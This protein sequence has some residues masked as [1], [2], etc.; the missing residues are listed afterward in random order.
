MRISVRGC[1][2]VITFFCASL[3]PGGQGQASL[4]QVFGCFD[5]FFSTRNV[6]ENFEILVAQTTVPSSDYFL[7]V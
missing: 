6:S 5:K 3:G 2:V 7:V 1:R 4:R